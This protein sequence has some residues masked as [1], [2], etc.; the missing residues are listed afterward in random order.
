MTDEMSIESG[1]AGY[2]VT[3]QILL[4]CLKQL[5][6]TS[7]VPMEYRGDMSI[8]Q[9]PAVLHCLQTASSD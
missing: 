7:A 8:F 3:Y 2:S 6:F 4:D 1:S 5:S 9:K